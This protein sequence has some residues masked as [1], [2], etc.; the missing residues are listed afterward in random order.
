LG[1]GADWRPFEWLAFVLEAQAGFGYRDAIDLVALQA[2]IRLALGSDVGAE[3][4]ASLPLVGPRAIDDG[5]LSMALEL[6]FNW[7]FD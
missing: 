3:L 2:G 5:A 4:A 6:T 1:I 7:R